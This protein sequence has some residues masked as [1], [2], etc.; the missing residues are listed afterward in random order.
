MPYRRL[1][2]R[3]TTALNSG[4]ISFTANPADTTSAS[5]ASQLRPEGDARW[6]LVNAGWNGSVRRGRGRARPAALEARPKPRRAA[7]GVTRAIALR[8]GPGAADTWRTTA[9]RFVGNF[10]RCFLL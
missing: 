3:R 8:R 4:A 5:I 10:F 7:F 1:R 2:R 9:F 6:L